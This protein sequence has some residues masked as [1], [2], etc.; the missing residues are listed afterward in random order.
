MEQIS[1][2]HIVAEK[3]AFAKTVLMPGDPKRSSF[4][5]KA[6][7]KDAVLINDVR[8]MQAYTGTYNGTKISVMASGMGMPS[9]SIFSYELFS[10]FGVENIIRVGTC[11]AMDENIKLG[12][13]IIA[14]KA[15]TDSNI[16]QNMN[17]GAQTKPAPQLLENAKKVA[18]ENNIN[19]VS[20]TVFTT[21]LFYRQD[22]S[23]KLAKQM[24]AS[25]IEMETYALYANA[26]L[27]NKNALAVFAV[28]DNII[29]K[30]SY[31]AQTRQDGLVKMLEYALK[32]AAQF[33]PSLS[34]PE[35]LNAILF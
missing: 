24:G 12:D 26:K 17:I 27:L 4:I 33:K 25:A 32:I 23:V 29:T 18:K 3:G 16:M 15:I 34:T 28:S 7:L 6:L 19:A 31:P 8:G 20:A 11:G 13:I 2:P 10:Y 9:M 5:A 30:E 22:D 35:R 14:S 21:D 1:S